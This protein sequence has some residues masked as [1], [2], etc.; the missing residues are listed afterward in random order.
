MSLIRSITPFHPSKKPFKL[1]IL[2]ALITISNNVIAIPETLRDAEPVKLEQDVEF[3]GLEVPEIAGHGE[4]IHVDLWWKTPKP[5]PPGVWVFLHAESH[6]SSCRMVVDRAPAKPDSE[7]FIHHRVTLTIPEYGDC[8]NERL[9]IYTGLYHR[10]GGRRYKTLEPEFL[11]DRIHAGFFD[12]EQG[13]QQSEPRALS[14]A[15]LSTESVMAIARPWLGWITG[16]LLATLMSLIL[17]WYLKRQ[18]QIKPFITTKKVM[19]RWLDTTLLLSAALFI[20]LSVLVAV[21]FVK[22]D[23]YISWRYSYNL[24]HGDGL[25]F[26]PDVRLEGF[27]TFL[28]IFVMAPFEWLG[29]DMVFVCEVIGVILAFLLVIKLTQISRILGEKSLYGFEYFAAF[30]LAGSSSFARWSTSGMEQ[31]LAMFLPIWSIYL[32]W[33][34]EEPENSKKKPLIISGIIMGLGCLTRP[35]VHLIGLIVGLS[36]VYKAL[37]QKHIITNELL[38]WGVG[39]VAITAP[40]HIFRYIYFGDLA[41]NTYYVKTGDSTLIM[42]SGLKMVSEMFDFNHLGWLLLLTPFA[43]IDKRR[44]LEKVV[45][46]LVSL[47]FMG[48]MVKIGTDEMSWHRL[49][50]PALPF[51]ILLSMNGLTNLAKLVISCVKDMQ[52]QYIVAMFTWTLLLSWT[53][54]NFAFTGSECG[55]FNGRGGSLNGDPPKLGR[56]LTRHASPAALVAFQDMGAGPYHAPDIQFLDFIGL[57]NGDIAKMRYNYGLSAFL[58]TENQQNIEAFEKDAQAYFFK[59]NP[60]WTILTTYIPK[61]DNTMKTVAEKYDKNPVPESLE[62]YIGQNGYQFGIYN[63]EFKKKYVHVKTWNHSQANY[64]SLFRR[65]DLWEQTPGEVVL[66]EVPSGIS[67]TQATFEN[68]LK[69]L[70]TEQPTEVTEHHELMLTSWWQLSDSMPADTYFFL[71]I[72]KEGYR[73]PYDHIPGEWMYPADRWQKGQILEN[74]VGITLPY[75]M[76]PGTYSIFMGVYNK[77]TGERLKVIDGD[78]DGQNRLLLG[79]VEVTDLVVPFDQLVE[80]TVIEKERKYPERMIKHGRQFGQ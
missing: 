43:F 77:S 63:D 26:N 53:A 34:I 49:Y 15:D 50:L 75:D 37:R 68:G 38:W 80:R 13:T 36:L 69:L 47:G 65:R 39:I 66:D 60:E 56:Y 62:P 67:G 14:Q 79:Q 24:V 58:A 51:L 23:A 21:D 35:E 76:Q 70:G 59:R 11:D 30:W 2:F 64:Y 32:L 1:I 33:R 28:W 16:L 29:M 74:R 42:I 20:L 61:N 55:W 31:A 7:G 9:Q 8:Q 5:I 44:Q 25:S 57:V 40:A 72:E 54:F 41:P 4:T 46:L 18:P 10:E 3:L 52:F 19:P 12:I 71:H 17:R 73:L 48:Y 22:D 78:H 6:E 27:S 45:C